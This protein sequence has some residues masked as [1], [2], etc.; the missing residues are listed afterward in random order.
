MASARCSRGC[1]WLARP[2]RSASSPLT[3]RPDSSRSAAVAAPTALRSAQAM[4]YS[5]ASPMRE[6][7]VV[8]TASSAAMRTSA[9]QRMHQAQAGGRAVEHRDDRP[10]DG[11]K[12]RGAALVVGPAAEV[13]GARQLVSSERGKSSSLPPLNPVT[14]PPAQNARPAPVSTMT[15][16]ASSRSAAC[17]ACHTSSAIT[18]VQAFSASGRFSVTVATWSRTSYRI[19]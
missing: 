7:A 13:V 16:T 19:C 15:R 6:N 3:L 10:L 1:S 17:M 18:S 11:R 4:P 5:D 8:I 14:S 9:E 2:S 12:V